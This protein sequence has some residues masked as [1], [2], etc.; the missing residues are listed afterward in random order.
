M[1]G[2]DGSVTLFDANSLGQ[3][4]VVRA[5]HL[6]VTGVAFKPVLDDAP[7]ELMSASADYSLYLMRGHG[8]NVVR[9]IMI[10][11]SMILILLA[12]LYAF[13]RPE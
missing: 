13:L 10:L 9:N 4:R 12:S 6:P 3:I 1:G 7:V 2:S 8:S 11:L 5:H